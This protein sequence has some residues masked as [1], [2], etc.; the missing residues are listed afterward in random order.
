MFDIIGV[1]QS[2]EAIAKLRVREADLRARGV[3]S[4]A[5]FGSTSREEAG[6]TSDVDLLIDLDESRVVTL[7]DLSALKFLASEAL[8][9]P[10][11]IAI[12]AQLR[13]SYRKNIEADAIRVF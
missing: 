3:R 8:G 10:V 4:L 6:S 11:D 2:S 5:I 12:R 1:M 13:P 9:E 7:L